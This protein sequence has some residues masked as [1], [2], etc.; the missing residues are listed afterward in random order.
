MV[1][2]APSAENWRIIGHDWAVDFLRRTLANGRNRHAYLITGSAGLGKMQLGL[3]FAMALACEAEDPAQRPCFNCRACDAIRRRAHPDLIL[4]GGDAPL[5][6]DDVRNVLRLLSLKPYSARYRIAILDDFH[7]VAPLVQDALLKTMEEPAP[8]AIVILLATSAERV[9]PTIRSRAQHIPLRPI[10]RGVVKAQ[11]VGGGCDE[12][13]AEL[14]AG[15]SGGRIGWALSTLQDDAPL[16]FRQEMLDMLR[17]VLA[18]PRLERMK[19]SDQL[20]RRAGREKALLRDVLEVWQSYWRDVLLHCSDSP[21]KPCNID[22]SGEIRAVAG[23]ISPGQALAA[24]EATGYTLRAL[25]TNAN[26][27]LALDALF[28]QYPGL[29]D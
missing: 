1:D 20:S 29:A 18:G 24:L 2:N 6:I 4:A 13:R 11:L 10:P 5:K 25:D 3:A 23:H 14:V 12:E 28:L 22:R 26:L 17:D 21:V 7:L 9:L 27:R 15:L 16:A 8:H 19:I